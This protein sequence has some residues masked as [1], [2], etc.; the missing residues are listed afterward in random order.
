MF[1]VMNGRWLFL[2]GALLLPLVWANGALADEGTYQRTKDGKSIVWNSYPIP[3]E[4]VEWSGS[5]DKEGYATGYGT[6]AWYK[7]ARSNFTFSKPHSV[8]SGRFSGKMVKGKLEGDVVKEGSSG[9]GSLISWTPTKGETITHAKFAGGTRVGE[10]VIGPAPS[11]SKTGAALDQ[12]PK[13]PAEGASPAPSQTAKQ[14]ISAPVKET[15]KPADDSLRSVAAPPSS[16]KTDRP[17]EASPEPPAAPTTTTSSASTERPQL[18]AKEVIELA[19]SVARAN[20]IDLSRYQN[21]QVQYAAEEEAW[22][23]SYDQKTA[24]GPPEPG[25]N[26]IVSVG[27]KTKRTS[28]GP[29]KF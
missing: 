13:V 17:A 20:G 14:N 3:G 19:D 4:T 18:T 25:R 23:V 1:V 6:V 11:S 15:A 5:Q 16:L 9:G 12:Q 8:L 27:D 28:I 29:G 26:F 10:W 21:P 7:M 22:A 24:G 2:C